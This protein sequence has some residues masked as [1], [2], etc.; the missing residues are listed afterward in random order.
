MILYFAGVPGGSLAGWYKREAE[1]VPMWT[2]RLWTYYWII[3]HRGVMEKPDCIEMFLDS[4]AFSAWTKGAQIRIRDYIAFIKRH[5]QYIDHYANLDVIADTFKKR[6]AASALYRK[7]AEATLHN[8]Q[9]MEKAGLNPIPVFHYGE[10]FEFLQMYL[11]KYE[12]IALGGLVGVPV[13]LAIEFLDKC[14]SDYICD[15]EG[16]PKVK[17]HGFGL[18]SLRIMLRYPFYSV[19]STSWVVTGR[20]GGIYVPVYK[21]GKWVY[22]ENSLK[23]TVSNRSPN[24]KDKGKHIE[25]LPPAMKKQV[26][27]Y[28]HSKGFVLGKSSFKQVPNGY[29]LQENEKWAEKADGST[30]TR[31]VEVIEE[32]GLCNKYQLRDEINIIYFNDLAKHM[33]EWPWKFSI[34]KST[35]L[36]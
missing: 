27:K 2:H 18:T 33:K 9:V 29:K 1:L 16:M 19:D 24:I 15:N 20:N 28:I 14:F 30:N 36:F 23:I 8:Q 3:E 10:P 31:M 26:L 25:T 35:S 17:V 34:D 21:N 7:A 22:D 32:P 5:Q 4:G 11:D 12:Y 6:G 13:G